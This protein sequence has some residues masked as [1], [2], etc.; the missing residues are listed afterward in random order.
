MNKQFRLAGLIIVLGLVLGLGDW[1]RQGWAAGQTGLKQVSHKLRKL[2]SPAAASEALRP[3]TRLTAAP[4]PAAPMATITV[5]SLADG[6]ANA[7]N[8]PHATNCRLRDAI[9]DAASGDTINFSVTGT[10]TLNSG[11]LS[12][13]KNLTIDGPGANLLTI[14][15]NATSRVFNIGNFT[16]AF[17]GLTIANGRTGGGEP[18]AGILNGGNLALT[19]SAI[20]GNVATTNLA[21]GIYNL[22][23][24]LT[25]TNST[26]SGN[27]ATGNSSGGIDNSNGTVTITNSTIS[28]NSAAN[29]GGGIGTSGGTLT[30]VNSTI[31]DNSSSSGG[32]GIH[33][34]STT[35]NIRNSLI[36]G[37][38]G[39]GSAS[40]VSGTLTSLGNNLIGNNLGATITPTTGDLIGT[41][42]APINPLLAP[43]GNYGGTTQT[44][45]L[46]PGSPALNAGNNCVLTNSCANNNIGFNLTTDQRGAGFNRQVG[47]AVDIGAHES[48]IVTVTSLADGAANA[49][50]CPHATNC[51]LR[52]A[53]AKAASGDMINFSI[54]GTIALTSGELSISKHLA[55][56]GPGANLL[57]ISGNDASRVLNI[58]NFTVALDGLT[59]ANGRTGSG[60]PG[61]GISNQGNLTIT[62]SA[63]T[64]NVATTNLAGGIYH[65]NGTLAIINS[66]I[67]GNSAT[68]NSSGGIFNGG[69]TVTIINS[70][71]SGNSAANLGG[72]IGTNVGA[73]TL[74]NST[75]S[76][77]SSGSG[78]NGINIISTTVNI[79][80][81]LIAENIGSAS[82][83]DVF[84]A[85]TSLGYNL[86]GNNSGATIT[87]TTG[88][89]I[90]TPASPINPLLAPLGNYGG[91]TQTHAL[92]PGSPALN[93]G[94]NCVLT[95][96]CASNNLGYNLTTD[97]RG[98][99]FNRQVGSAVDIGAFESRGFTLAILSG[100]NQSAGV[101]SAFAN[102]LRV[103]VTATGAG[104]PVTGGKATFTP[105][106]SGA[107]AGIAGN[108]ATI[109]GTTATSGT[110]TA[111][112]IIGG[113]YNVAASA[114]GAT[115]INFSLTNTNVPP[116][117]TAAAALSRQRGSAGTVST[118]ATVND[119]QTPVGSLVVTATTVPAGITVTSIT[120][121]AG[122]IT[123][124]IAASC[125]ATI[126]AN[127]VVLT[128]TDGNSG[129]ATANLTVNVTANTAPTL[130]YAAA[131]V[132]AGSTTTNSPASAT[133]NGSISSFAVQS[134]GTYTGTISVNAS[135]VVSI[136]NAAPVGSHTITIRA[137][138]NCGSTTNATF[139]LTVNNTPPTITAAA[140]L[141]RQR[142]SAGTVNTIATVNDGQTPVGSL[143]VTA[144][145]VPAG[146]AVTSITNTAGTITANVSAGCAA[147]IGANTVV[148]TVTDSN[149]GTATAN[150]IV[151]VSANAAPSLAYPASSIALG[152][153]T[154]V[155]STTA[156]DNGSITGYSIVSVTP[157]M[158]VAP[159]VNSSGVVSITNAGPF[160]SHTIVVRATDNCSVTADASFTLSVGCGTIALNPTLLVNGLTFVSYAATLSATG[161][162]G[163]YIFSLQSGTLPAGL[164]LNGNMITGTPTMAGAS[165]FTIRATDDN[166]CFGE[167][168]YTVNIGS[169]GL[170]Y[171]PLARP[172][173][174]LDTRP[175]ASSNACFQPNAPIA[176]GTS[177]L[178]PA[179]GTCEGI[180]IPSNATTITGHATTVQ[181]GGGLLTLYPSD[182]P[183]PNVTNS[184]YLANEILNNAFTVGLG[185]S[186]GAFKIFVS[187]NTDLVVDVTGYYAPPSAGGLYFHPLPKP[188]R[189]LETRQGFTGCQATGAPL[190]GST[191]RT[192]TGVLTCDGVTIPTGAQALVGNA[193]TTNSAGSG[194]LTLYPADAA[195]PFASSSNFAA[196]VNRN[197]PFTVGL[198]LNGEFKIYTAQTTDL[199]IDV[200][201]Y[202]STQASDAN[203]Q[204]L[205][206]NSLGSPLR[207]LDT[208][209][210]QTA[211]YTPD[212]PMTGGTVYTQNTQIACTNLTPTARGLVGNVSALNVTSNGYLTFWPSNATQPTVA[213]SNY[214]TGRT[215]NRHFTVGLGTDAAF[216]RFAA[217]TTD[218]IVDISGFFAP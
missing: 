105:P 30:L 178:Q 155:S 63:V 120:N 206:F 100:N 182:A 126:G 107:S 184:N 131:A 94:N 26:I 29:L 109:S 76:D 75:I 200:I 195:Q 67:F 95:N 114:T 89:L 118:I 136:S 102:P 172:V 153:S 31:S 193:T 27:A 74:I 212:A 218:I 24:T 15:G 108:P 137:T 103:T 163:S 154:T 216:K 28:G 39:S 59:I 20:S 159:T 84:G 73:L 147:T 88:D 40:D 173:R 69:G 92:L 42:A 5:T 48:G 176:G 211:C 80:N 97:Q 191:T 144:T 22:N 146:I 43:L 8:C 9:A 168:T 119:G 65:Q 132:N 104:E 78:G 44:H 25:I 187:S 124:N 115:S 181:S 185:A 38:T 57:T 45:A 214:Q 145:T 12:I 53:I 160:G 134:Q 72:G 190:Q 2:F 4:V 139:T 130:S 54:T 149:S 10:I 7:A 99:G 101:S 121:T 32:R 157:A 161:G 46:L 113:P 19:S 66:T 141:T 49:A 205:L 86:I 35:V 150:L 116:T 14:S 171:Y 180:T 123:A 158:T 58:G 3:A 165:T 71:I 18:G 64:G 169:T 210:G 186:D 33:I 128:V 13:S 156:T 127:I 192:Q 82:G 83:P 37:N 11:Q 16:V 87:P 162:S 52:D 36:A 138:D 6:V 183:Q 196:G 164:N 55:I 166:A 1:Q 143:V 179:R 93:A 135:G 142:G 111:N 110:V 23:G 50:N 106:G 133:D 151:N 47:T 215:F 170:M 68:A 98:A 34:F 21:G 85:L 152:G 204:G 125:T 62:S 208:R 148:L 213:T 122:T 112:A 129:T 188:I 77:N 41:P 194:Y 203:G 198:S 167:R 209:A 61:A 189:L 177:R 217:T 79:R 96:S 201:G 17:D 199:V 56:D 51:R 90:G 197:A 60:A 202:F 81:S 91:P 140:A 117:I 207:L 174:L 70:T 175:G